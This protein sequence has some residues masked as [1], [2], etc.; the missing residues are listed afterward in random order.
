VGEV[1][2][3]EHSMRAEAPRV[4]DARLEV[5]GWDT[6]EL[7]PRSRYPNRAWPPAVRFAIHVERTTPTGLLCR[8][9]PVS[10]AEV[11]ALMLAANP[12][13]EFGRW[14]NAHGEP[15]ESPDCFR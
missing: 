8:V 10:V 14:V 9:A 11:L 7:R 12:P 3:G 1:K 5:T 15:E 4:E 13:E 2:H 6:A